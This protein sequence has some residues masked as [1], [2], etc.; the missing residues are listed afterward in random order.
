MGKKKSEIKEWKCEVIQSNVD[1]T[2]GKFFELYEKDKLAARLYILNGYFESWRYVD[3]QQ[4]NNPNVHMI[5]HEKISYGVSITL[6]IYK[7]VKVLAKYY[8]DIS[9]GSISKSMG[10]K[11]IPCKVRDIQDSRIKQYL[12]KLMPWIEF[13]FELNLPITFVTVANKKLY[14]T[15]KL[16]AWYWGTNYPTAVKLNLLNFYSIRKNPKNIT[17]LENLNKNILENHEHAEIFLEVFDMAIQLR[18]VVNAGWSL[19]RLK[20]EHNKMSKEITNTLYVKHDE[21]LKIPYHF[22]IIVPCLR[23]LGFQVG[24]TTKEIAEI[25]TSLPPDKVKDYIDNTNNSSAILCKYKHVRFRFYYSSNKKVEYY[26]D[27]GNTSFKIID[28]SIED[29]ILGSVKRVNSYAENKK[30][31]DIRKGKI[32]KIMGDTVET[33]EKVVDDDFESPGV[34]VWI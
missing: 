32:G 2:F 20:N 22:S 7:S 4:P 23:D 26:T 1:E 10:G 33:V 17:K 15:K 19:K 29:Y 13:V 25:C 24:T 30:K 8:V 34:S 31:N 21:P 18:K 28:K 5:L 12:I 27:L 14:S 3:F 16:L 6:R 11:F 9:T